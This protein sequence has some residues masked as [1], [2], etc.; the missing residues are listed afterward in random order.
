[1]LRILR[2][3]QEPLTFPEYPE[4]PFQLFVCGATPSGPCQALSSV[5]LE[6]WNE[7]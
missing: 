2:K 5:V 3:E 6:S 1:M 4:H 7:R